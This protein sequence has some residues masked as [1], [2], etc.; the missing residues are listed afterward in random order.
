M[1][2]NS[3]NPLHLRHLSQHLHHHPQAA[4]LGIIIITG[5]T[6]MGTGIMALITGIITTAIGME[7]TGITIIGEIRGEGNG[8]SK[9]KEPTPSN[10][11]R[12]RRQ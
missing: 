4:V 1:P 7:V 12:R 8:T 9:Q 2:A 11:L 5:T 3:S 10:M 6:L